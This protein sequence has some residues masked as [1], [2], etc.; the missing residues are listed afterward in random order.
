MGSVTAILLV[1]N[2]FKIAQLFYVNPTPFFTSVSVIE[3]KETF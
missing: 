2:D 1:A 3:G